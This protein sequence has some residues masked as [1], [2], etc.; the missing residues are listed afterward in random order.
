VP[1]ASV[2]PVTADA[3]TNSKYGGILRWGVYPDSAHFDL[4]QNTSVVNSTFQ[5][6]LYN[7]ILRYN[8]N[9]A[10]NTIIADLAKS[11]EISEDGKT[12][13]FPFREGVKFTDGSILTAEDVVATWSRIFDP[14]VGVNMPRR[15]IYNAYDPSVR[16]VD[17]LTVEFTFEK[18][19]P[20]G[21]MLNGFALE[22]H[23]IFKKATLDEFNNDLKRDGKEVP[24][25]GA[26]MF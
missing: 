7:G 19:P 13:T 24:T 14:P 10:G 12:W 17:P 20:E 2:N 23:G 16:A 26:F 3:Y 11:W 6:M 5:M 1:V 9:D 25:T 4:A 22:W 8:P 18:A 21:V 15:G